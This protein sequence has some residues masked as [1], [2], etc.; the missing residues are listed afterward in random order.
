[1][2]GPEWDIFSKII[3]PGESLRAPTMTKK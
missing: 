3:L 1:V 2:R